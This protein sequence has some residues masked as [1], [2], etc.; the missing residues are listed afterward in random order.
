MTTTFNN[1]LIPNQLNITINTSVPGF[2]KIK[3]KSFMTIPDISKDSKNVIF[4]PLFKLNKNVVDKVPE[5]L[6][7]K[8]FFNKGLFESLINYTSPTKAPS[9]LLATQN[10]IVDNNIKVTLDTIFPE[11]SVLYINKSPYVISDLQW[12]KGDWNIDKKIKEINIDINK[13]SNPYLYQSVAKENIIAGETQ[14]KTLSPSIVYGPNYN[15]IKNVT[16]PEPKT[17]TTPDTKSDTKHDIE[18]NAQ[19]SRGDELDTYKNA[20]TFT[21]EP[22]F[23]KAPTFTKQPDK[24]KMKIADASSKQ[25]R[26]FFRKV[27]FRNLLITLYNKTDPTTK[28]NMKKSLLITSGDKVDNSF[29]TMYEKSVKEVNVISN[30]G[31]GNCFFIAVADA[32]NYHNY[33]NQENRIISG[34]YG[35]NDNVF[36]QTYL[37]QLVLNYI[38]QGDIDFAFGMGGANASVL[39]YEFKKS[40]EYSIENN[41]KNKFGMTTDEIYKT[42]LNNIYFSNQNFLVKKVDNVPLHENDYYS[43]FKVLPRHELEEYILSSDYWA[44]Q[45]AFYALRIQL[46]LNVIPLELEKRGPKQ[47]NFIII[48]HGGYFE[49]NNDIQN[50]NDWNKYLFLFS[51]G[52]HYELIT[53]KTNLNNDTNNNRKMAIKNITRKVNTNK[54]KEKNKIIFDKENDFPPL[55]IFF[56]IFAS[57]YSYKHYDVRKEYAYKKQYMEAFEKLSNSVLSG[58]SGMEYYNSFIDFFPGA[59]IE[60]PK[61][62]DETVEVQTGGDNNYVTTNP[63]TQLAYEITI[64]LELTPGTSLSPDELKNAKCN[65][66][67]NSIRKS[68]SGLTG[69][70]YVIKPIYNNTKKNTPPVTGGKTKKRNR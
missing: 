68:W 38:K 60:E 27:K 18:V 17:E 62:G 32:I 34:I 30:D 42:V 61:K 55:Y 37:R 45:Y 41:K 8:Q 48:P 19:L 39:N 58:D 16:T 5:N 9:L 3:Y 43:P 36:T 56:L 24:N 26:Q 15:G 54:L 40:F 47:E 49:K 51:A 67:L 31:G 59:R 25:L 21:K 52:S 33:F 44:D 10:G 4:N 35:T 12:S 46:K 6:R 65:R 57:D 53:F 28:N 7:K 63:D 11:N 1:E 66:K 29:K 14:L 69:K 70:P 13:I 22:T 23:T 20:S 2:Q 64:D 50:F